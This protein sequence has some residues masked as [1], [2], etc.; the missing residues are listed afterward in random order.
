VLLYDIASALTADATKEL[1]GVI[2]F[3]VRSMFHTIES[4]SSLSVMCVLDSLI[5]F[6]FSPLGIRSRSCDH[7]TEEVSCRHI[8]FN[9]IRSTFLSINFAHPTFGD[10]LSQ[11]FT[12]LPLFSFCTVFRDFPG[13]VLRRRGKLHPFV[14]IPDSTASVCL[15]LR[16]Y[17]KFDL[18]VSMPHG[19][20]PL[21]IFP[22]GFY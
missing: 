4:L 20:A 1:S 9:P 10:A 11:R 22:S 21:N 3:A 19:T 14:Q 2:S 17:L 12:S 13:T 7:G 6:H 18:P 5:T 15:S 8:L 16:I